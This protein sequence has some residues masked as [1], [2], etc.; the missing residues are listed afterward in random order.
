MKA[1]IPPALALFAGMALLAGCTKSSSDEESW[2][3]VAPGDM[4][5]SQKEQQKRAM[6]AKEAM[7]GQLMGKLTQEIAKGGPASA[8][9]VCQEEAPRIAQQVSTEKGIKI[10]RT[11]R[12]LRNPKNQPPAWAKELIEQ[13]IAEPAFFANSKGEFAALLPI[14]LLPQCVVCH[15]SGEQI[16]AEVRTALTQRYPDDQATGFKE[17]DL[18]GWFWI[19]V[20]K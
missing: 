4:S 9:S 18:R 17:G 3:P 13:S 6:G 20:P 7:F 15:G 14:K 10:G 1:T 5:T 12:K 16:P 19:E 8:I 2:Q 11:S